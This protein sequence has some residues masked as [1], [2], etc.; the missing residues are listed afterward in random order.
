LESGQKIKFKWIYSCSLLTLIAVLKQ[1][2]RKL[3]LAFT[4]TLFHKYAELGD[5]RKIIWQQ[6]NTIFHS[7]NG[8]R[9]QRL[10]HLQEEEMRKKKEA[11][12]AA[13]RA[14]E[15]ARKQGEESKRKAEDEAKL[16]LN[17][18]RKRQEK[19]RLENIADEERERFRRLRFEEEKERQKKIESAI[20]A[21][22]Q[23]AQL[24]ES[25]QRTQKENE[26]RKR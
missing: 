4:A 11:L 8:I 1:G 15:E 20:Q 12:E 23:E 2:A 14:E 13:I 17:E 21:E 25:K 9:R 18:E 6:V 26:E 22:T 5:Q 10:F 7:C 3:N 24:R 19:Q 16:K